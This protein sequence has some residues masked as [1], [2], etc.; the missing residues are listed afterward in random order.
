MNWDSGIFVLLAGAFFATRAFLRL[1]DSEYRAALA[2][3]QAINKSRQRMEAKIRARLREL[4]ESA[5]VE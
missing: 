4:S 3:R 2:A 1:L 5:G